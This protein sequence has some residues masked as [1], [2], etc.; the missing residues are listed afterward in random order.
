MKE[1]FTPRF[2]ARLGVL[3]CFTILV[4]DIVSFFNIPKEKIPTVNYFTLRPIMSIAL[5]SSFGVFLMTIL[6]IFHKHKLVIAVA[7]VTLVALAYLKFVI[8]Y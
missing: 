7:V 3:A 1:V 6:T 8:L 2:F 4:L 5:L